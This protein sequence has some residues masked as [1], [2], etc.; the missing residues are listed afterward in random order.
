MKIFVHHGGEKLGPYSLEEAQDLLAQ[1]KI[2]ATDLG[3]HEGLETWIPVSSL[4]A[5][6]GSGV[7]PFLPLNELIR[8]PGAAAAATTQGN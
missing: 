4:P 5:M 3:W 1:G 7:V 6:G 8:T 2:L